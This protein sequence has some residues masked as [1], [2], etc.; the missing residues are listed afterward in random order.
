MGVVFKKEKKG[1][2]ETGVIE[3]TRLGVGL[4][5]EKGDFTK[6]KQVFDYLMRM[7]GVK[8][9]MRDIEH[10]SF[11]SGRVARVSIKG[12]DV[13]YVGEMHPSVLVNFDLDAPVACFELNLSELFGVL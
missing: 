5:E 7:L 4:C 2:M 3:M 6:I 9:E 13:A 10:P 11:I 12:K 8:Y 1:M